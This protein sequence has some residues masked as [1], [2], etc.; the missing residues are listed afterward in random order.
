VGQSDVSPDAFTHFM[1]ILSGAELHF[2]P[3]TSDDLILLGQEFGHNSLIRH[4]FPQL[5]FPRCE[6]NVHELL[7][8]LERSPR[9]TIIKAE[10]QSIRDCFADMQRRL[11]MIEEQFDEKLETILL[12]LEKMTELVKQPSQK[13]PSN[14]RALIEALIEWIAVKSI[15]FRSV[16]HPLSQEIIQ[17]A[18]P[19]IPAP[20]YNT[21]KYHITRLAEVYRQLLEPQ[22]KNYC[23]LMIDGAKNSDGVFWRSLCSWK[24]TFGS[25]S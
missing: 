23:S 1:E 9:G 12:E 10:F 8:E 19:D 17:H 25:W 13:C 20:V 2:S 18:N 15:S 14:Q 4:L 22:K 3:E 16:N 11:S 5:D 24:D 21:L 7:K 6:G